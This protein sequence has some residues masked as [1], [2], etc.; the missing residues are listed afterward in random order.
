MDADWL[1]DLVVSDDPRDG[2]DYARQPYRDEPIRPQASDRAATLPQPLREA[3]R[4]AR[5]SNPWQTSGNA[6]FAAQAKMLADYE[7]DTVFT[8]TFQRYFPTYESMSD[9]QLRGYFGFRTRLRRGETPKA[10]VSFVYVHVYELLHLIGAADAHDAFRQLQ[11]LL[12]AYG[13]LDYNLHHQLTEWLWDFVVY[14]HLPVD[15]LN[16][17]P[18]YDR[19]AAAQTLTDWETAPDD[20]LASALIL[21]SPYQVER[22]RFYK[23]HSAEFREALCLAYRAYAAYYQSHRARALS[24]SWFGRCYFER[25]RLF[26]GAVFCD[27]RS[28]QED[29]Y[30]INAL[31]SYRCVNR[32]WSRNSI[33]LPPAKPQALG[34]FIKTVDA[35]LRIAYN[36]PHP[37]RSETETAHLRE[38]IRDAVA[39]SMQAKR[40]REQPKLEFDFSKLDAIRSDADHTRD[41]LLTEEE[42]AEDAEPIAQETVEAPANQ[43]S[44]ALPID[45]AE[46]A[47]LRCLLDGGDWKAAAARANEMPSILADT[48]NEKLFDLFADTVIVFDGDRPEIPEDYIEELRGYV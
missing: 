17:L 29:S 26:A 31:C 42:T 47:F 38:L 21:L 10:P 24:E 18:N 15:D 41:Q 19:L 11:A 27:E 9:A 4:Y 25:C 46:A 30:E 8:G 37:I 39:Q 23:S 1:I 3:R 28:L 43:P 32:N 22:S 35:Q 40:E 6:V 5:E 7:D 13:T 33:V 36:D 16:G 12:A 2:R 45:E 20:A 14:Y 34:S 44:N 48:I